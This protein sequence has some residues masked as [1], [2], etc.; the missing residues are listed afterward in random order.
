MFLIS[1]GS[2]NIMVKEFTAAV[3]SNYQRLTLGRGDSGGLKGLKPPGTGGT[4]NNCVYSQFVVQAGG[5]YSA[6]NEEKPFSGCFPPL[7]LHSSLCSSSTYIQTHRGQSAPRVQKP[8]KLVYLHHILPAARQAIIPLH[9]THWR[10]FGYPFCSGG[11]AWQQ[12]VDSHLHNA[13]HFHPPPPRK[14]T[15]AC[16]CSYILGNSSPNLKNP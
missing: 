9:I 4:K 3:I 10:L 14:K 16:N 5:T 8:K 2:N 6:L 15:P 11:R 12:R 1:S 13:L 7:P